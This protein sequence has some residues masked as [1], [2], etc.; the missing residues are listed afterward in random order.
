MTAGQAS[1]T[2]HPARRVSFSELLGGQSSP[3]QRGS[4]RDELGVYRVLHDY[5]GCANPVQGRSRPGW[6]K[7]G[8]SLGAV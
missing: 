8:I 6:M 4:G 1:I 3:R 5:Y 7:P 2:Y